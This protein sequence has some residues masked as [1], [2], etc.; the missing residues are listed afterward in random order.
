MPFGR[1][2]SSHP[3][4][5]LRDPALPSHTGEQHSCFCSLHLLG[6]PPQRGCKSPSATGAPPALRVTSLALFLGH[7]GF[8]SRVS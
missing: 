1:V 8:L 5:G 2:K 6:S 4:W 7:G 3:T